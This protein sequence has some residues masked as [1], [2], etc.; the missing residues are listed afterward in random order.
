MYIIFTI[1]RNL[2][3]KHR[4]CGPLNNGLR[5]SI[6]TVSTCDN[7]LLAFIDG[8]YFKIGEEF[9]LEMLVLTTEE[10][11]LW[12]LKTKGDKHEFYNC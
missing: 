7:K 4:I 5:L 12:L 9:Y 6:T 1:N 8:S 10:Y 3:N 2:I 11:L